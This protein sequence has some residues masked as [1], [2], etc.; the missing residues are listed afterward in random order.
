MQSAG[1][2]KNACEREV[3]IGENWPCEKKYSS[4]WFPHFKPM[5][6]FIRDTGESLGVSEQIWEQHLFTS[7]PLKKARSSVEADRGPGLSR[8][9]LN[10]PLPFPVCYTP[11]WQSGCY[12]PLP[13]SPWMLPLTSD[14]SSPRSLQCAAKAA[15][16][17]FDL[18]GHSE[19]FNFEL[20]KQPSRHLSLSQYR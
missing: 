15:A 2:L 14:L 12:C 19:A 16:N 9:L 20:H 11:D 17:Y 8:S 10:P 1:K 3:P 4:G 7:L 5:K 6:T 13:C 18:C